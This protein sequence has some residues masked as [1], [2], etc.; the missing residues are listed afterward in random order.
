MV[1]DRD[2]DRLLACF[3]DKAGAALAEET[4]AKMV[5]RLQS[6]ESA[7]LHFQYRENIVPLASVAAADVPAKF[8][9]VQQPVQPAGQEQCY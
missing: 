7:G 2:L 8:G 3:V 9:F 4:V 5:E 6:G 1:D